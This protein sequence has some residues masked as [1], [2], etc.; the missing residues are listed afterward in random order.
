MH[1]GD[2][3]RKVTRSLTGR[4]LKFSTRP[5]RKCFTA[6]APKLLNASAGNSDFQPRGNHLGLAEL[7]AARNRLSHPPDLTTSGNRPTLF[8]VSRVVEKNRQLDGTM[9]KLWKVRCA[10]VPGIQ[11]RCC[12]VRGKN[13]KRI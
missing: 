7:F 2:L 10:S 8:D 13:H 3:A 6:T 12:V 1:S 11:I 5:Y 4:V 9:S